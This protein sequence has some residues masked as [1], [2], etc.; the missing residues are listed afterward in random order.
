MRIKLTAAAIERLKL[1]PPRGQ[2]DY[3]DRGYPGFALRLSY[4]GARTFE[5]FYRWIGKPTRRTLG[6]WPSVTLSAAREQWRRDREAL[7]RGEDPRR[8]HGTD[9]PDTFAAVAAEWLH[10]DQG[11]N[12]SRSRVG[13]SITNDALPWLGTRP[14]NLIGRTDV[15]KVIDK[16]TD[17]GSPVAARQLHAHLHRLFRWAVGRGIVA[18][19]PMA[20]LPKPAAAQHRDRVLGEHEIAAVWK[21]CGTI[22]WPFGPAVQLLFLTGLRRSEIGELRWHEIAG[23]EIKLAGDRTKNG[24]PRTVALST[25]AADIIREL[26]R[27]GTCE[28]AFSINGRTPIG[29]W[30]KAKRRIDATVALAPWHV[31][32]IRRTVATHLQ[33]LGARLET[34]EAILGHTGGSR[35]GIVAV[36][37]Q[38]QFVDE[39]R[40]AL[41]LWAIEVARIVAGAPP[42]PMVVPMRRRGHG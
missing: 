15:V 28:F 7:T 11:A 34:I 36:Y 19:N 40:A 37:Q 6:Q 29:G 27:V 31:H 1:P 41:D 16:V 10:R 32:D 39:A 4:G 24:E 25:A 17:R 33:R 8:P 3:F 5:H 18:V 38:H 13:R 21:A 30:S 35:S 9:K 20:H 23:G 2:V 14:V 22:G 26:P 42:A 12:R